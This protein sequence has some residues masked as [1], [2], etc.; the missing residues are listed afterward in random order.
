VHL[1]HVDVGGERLRPAGGQ[2]F[3]PIEKYRIKL[4]SIGFFVT[5]KTPIIW[6]GPMVMSAVR[7]F[8]QETLWGAQDFLI[9]DLPPG[10]GDAQ[11]T[12]SQQVALDGVV[13]VTTPQDA[14][15]WPCGRCGC[16]VRCSRSS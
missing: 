2:S 1:D 14:G 10:T 4:I 13:V 6:R 8:L 9:V 12:L 5:D 15:R 3:Y 11:M 7:Q 16:F